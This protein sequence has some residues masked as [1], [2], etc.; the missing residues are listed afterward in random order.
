MPQFLL[1][2]AV[3]DQLRDRTCALAA[4]FIIA[5]RHADVLQFVA[6]TI[7][8]DDAPKP[9]GGVRAPRT[10]KSR[11]AREA[12]GNGA[13]CT[14]RLAKREADDQALVNAMRSDSEG[15]INDWA[16]AIGKSR[17]S[18]VSALHRLRDAGLA[19]SVEGVW[20]LTEERRRASQRSVGL[21]H[22]LPFVNACTPDLVRAS[23][24]PRAAAQRSPRAG[25]N[26]EASL[27]IPLAV[28]S[29]MNSEAVKGGFR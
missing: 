9:N 21:N 10:R 2:D 14:P 15:S 28:R 24:G 29:K 17:T 18:C 8:V 1:S 11:A 3:A 5:A 13:A 19:E 4:A 23:R 25:R 22:R 16:T 27:G 12:N 20:R 6:R 7:G 26:R